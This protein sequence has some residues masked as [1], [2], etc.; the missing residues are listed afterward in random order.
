MSFAPGYRRVPPAL[1]GCWRIPNLNLR[2]GIAEPDFEVVASVD[3]NAH[4]RTC[5]SAD[6]R[7]ANLRQVDAVRACDRRHG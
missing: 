3:P 6:A 4:H 1:V 7:A 5:G 2:V